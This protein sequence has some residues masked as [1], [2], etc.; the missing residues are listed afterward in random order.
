MQSTDINP[1]YEDQESHFM[2]VIFSIDKNIDKSI[3]QVI[4]FENSAKG[5]P[6]K[7]FFKDRR[8]LDIMLNREDDKFSK[9]VYLCEIELQKEHFDNIELVSLFVPKRSETEEHVVCPVKW[10]PL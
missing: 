8:D 10:R 7:V 6:V 5:M 9:I 2:T 4:D 1:L 3:H